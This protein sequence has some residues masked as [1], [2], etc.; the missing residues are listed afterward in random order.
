[1]YLLEM[2]ELLN[3]LADALHLQAGQQA[4]WNV[5]GS[6]FIQLHELFNSSPVMSWAS[7]T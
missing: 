2:I 4:H 1:M 5:K 7:S 3:V 6:D